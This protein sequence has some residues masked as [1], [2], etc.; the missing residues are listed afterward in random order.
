MSTDATDQP[1]KTDPPREVLADVRDLASL[2]TLSA[3]CCAQLQECAS[4]LL[5]RYRRPAPTT[6]VWERGEETFSGELLWESPTPTVIETYGN[7]KDATEDAAYGV[8]V[9]LAKRAGFRV[10]RR[11]P[12]GSGADFIMTPLDGDDEQFVHLEVSGIAERGD[13]GRRLDKKV[14][15]VRRVD[16]HRPW[17]AVVVHFESAT[18]ASKEWR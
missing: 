16:I 9:A 5:E 3:G 2:S 18:I 10:R 4:V 12:Q 15:Q 11:A 17:M 14:D 13:I 1:E 7:D 6:G 8:A